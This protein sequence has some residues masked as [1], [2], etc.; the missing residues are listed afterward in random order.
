MT[1][2]QPADQLPGEDEADFF[3]RLEAEYAVDAYFVIIPLNAK[4]LGTICEGGMLVRDFKWGA[5]RSSRSSSRGRR[6]RECQRE[7]F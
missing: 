3:A 1:V 7:H 4:V 6:P 2:M 5:N